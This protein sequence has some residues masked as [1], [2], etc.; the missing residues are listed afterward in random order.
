[1]G[2]ERQVAGGPEE[3][4]GHTDVDVAGRPRKHH[5]EAVETAETGR[6]EPTGY[7][8][9]RALQSGARG[10]ACF[11][12]TGAEMTPAGDPKGETMDQPDGL[13]DPRSQGID[14]EE[15]RLHEECGVFG[16]FG[17]PEAAAITAL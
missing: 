3:N 5:F 7:P 13:R 11:C 16:I 9:G 14:L 1:M 2:E 15:D 8:A 17:H 12:G 10:R 4:R 6:R